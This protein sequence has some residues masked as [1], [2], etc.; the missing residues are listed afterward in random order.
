MRILTMPEQDKIHWQ[1]GLDLTPFLE[2]QAAL[3]QKE[4]LETMGK[5][6]DK[7]LCCGGHGQYGSKYHKIYMGL[8]DAFLR[9]E[10]P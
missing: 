4:T 1:V 7:R 6:L 10:M 9:G 2:A 3:T 5:W 8:I